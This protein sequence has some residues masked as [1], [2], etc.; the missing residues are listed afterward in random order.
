MIYIISTLITIGSNYCV[1]HIT[2]F[3]QCAGILSTFQCMARKSNNITCNKLKFMIVS[4]KYLNKCWN[5]VEGGYCQHLP[6]IQESHAPRC[7]Y[8]RLKKGE[9]GYAMNIEIECI[10]WWGQSCLSVLSIVTVEWTD[11]STVNT[12]NNIF[13]HFYCLRF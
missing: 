3:F 8:C 2:R 13:Q 10:V 7:C 12:C 9:I 6:D 5:D 4:R 1:L 11:A